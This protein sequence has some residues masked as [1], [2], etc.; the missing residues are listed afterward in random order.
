MALRKNTYNHM[1]NGTKYIMHQP[2]DILLDHRTTKKSQIHFRNS[3][4]LMHYID[5]LVQERRNSN[6]NTLELRDSCTNSS[7]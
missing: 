2:N 7:I 4:P 5:G 1:N 6:A 3:D